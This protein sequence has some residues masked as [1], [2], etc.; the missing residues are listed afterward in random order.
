MAGKNED[1]LLTFAS[2]SRQC[3]GKQ[4]ALMEMRLL[5]ATLV[6]C[7]ELKLVPEQSHELANMLV[8]H[9]K[10]EQ[11]FIEVKR[12]VAAVEDELWLKNDEMRA[13]ERGLRVATLQG[14]GG[15]RKA[16]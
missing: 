8:L 10:E 12:R 15:K 9:L 16:Y 6:K 3:I 13:E 1:V 14:S 7:Y 4:F 2:A 11:Y 5:L